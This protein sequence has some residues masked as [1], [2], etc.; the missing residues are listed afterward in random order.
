MQIRRLEM[1]RNSGGSPA[2]KVL[3]RGAQMVD[4]GELLV[5]NGGE[6]YVDSVQ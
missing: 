3:R 2:W 4:G 5:I 6:E 1:E